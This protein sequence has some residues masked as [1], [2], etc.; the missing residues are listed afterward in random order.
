MCH[1]FSFITKGDGVPLYFNAE[2]RKALSF[3][4][5]VGLDSHSSIA[6]YFLNDPAAGDRCNKYEYSNGKFNADQI[7]TIND[8]QKMRLWIKD[9]V[10][11]QKFQDICLAVVNQD[12]REIKNIKNPS[13]R[14]QLAAVKQNKRAIEFIEKP[15]KAVIQYMENIDKLRR[16]GT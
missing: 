3:D 13:E 10:E 15:T 12:G 7:N 11:T 6:E 8:S 1:F 2:Q 5:C 16:K 4:C 9:F 14:V